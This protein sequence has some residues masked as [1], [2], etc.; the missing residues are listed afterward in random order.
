MQQ[1]KNEKK[2]S[3]DTNGGR[4]RRARIL[5]VEDDNT[6]Q[7]VFSK[8]LCDMGFDVALAEHGL[9]A[10]ALLLDNRPDVVLI[11]LQ[12]PI[13][14]CSSL[15]YFIKEVSPKTRVILLADDDKEPAWK[16]AAS[17]AIDSV[18][19]KPFKVRDFEKR[20]R[21]ALGV[22]RA[23]SLPVA[24]SPLG[25]PAMNAERNP[26]WRQGDRNIFC[27]L[28]RECLNDA[29]QGSWQ[30]W[31]CSDCPHKGNHKNGPDPL[32]AVTHSIEY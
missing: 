30:D 32:L 7:R 22:N 13:I 5:V 18:L 10:L 19:F 17:A 11:D 26:V 12:K 24:T 23:A 9:E 20:I 31:D 27:S 25:R 6:F 14:V 3:E 8:T 15:A 4:R 29:I 28:Y 21:E 1:V 16:Q 2:T